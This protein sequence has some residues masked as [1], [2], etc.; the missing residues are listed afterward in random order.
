M[1]LS[2]MRWRI[3]ARAKRSDTIVGDPAINDIGFEP[4]QVANLEVGDS[5]FGDESAHVA[6][7]HTEPDREVL[8]TEESG[9][10]GL[11]HDLPPSW[12]ESYAR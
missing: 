4:E 2:I 3:F 1:D 10:A 8:N 9:R 7:R 11:R 6:A 12:R 5:A